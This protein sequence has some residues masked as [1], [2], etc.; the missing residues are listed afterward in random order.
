MAWL[1]THMWMA[2]GAAAVCALTLG[3][4]LRGILMGGRVRRAEVEREVA[5]TELAQTREEVERLFAAQRA[6]PGT[7]AGAGADPTG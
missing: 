4:T 2:L 3:W 7:G 5:R 1:V 6:A